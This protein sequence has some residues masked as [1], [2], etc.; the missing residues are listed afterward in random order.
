MPVSLCVAESDVVHISRNCKTPAQ[1][2]RP[3]SVSVSGNFN[4]HDSYGS[5]SVT[6]F[7]LPNVNNC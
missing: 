6:Q 2:C 3:L 4:L 1:V 5:K 7:H